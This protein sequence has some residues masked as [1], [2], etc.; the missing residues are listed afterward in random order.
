[1]C[2][3]VFKAPL[4]SIGQKL[5]EDTRSV[6]VFAKV[7]TVDSQFRPGMYVTA[8]IMKEQASAEK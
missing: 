4:F 5:D 2:N 8:R 7:D 6:D 3:S 1:M